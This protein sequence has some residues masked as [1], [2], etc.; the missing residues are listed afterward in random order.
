MNKFDLN[1]LTNN[2]KQQSSNVKQQRQIFSSRRFNQQFFQI[3]KNSRERSTI[4]S[5]FTKKKFFFEINTFNESSNILENDAIF[6][7]ISNFDF[8]DI[9][10]IV[11]NEIQ[12][13]LDRHSK[14]RFKRV[15]FVDFLIDLIVFF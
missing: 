9:L 1:E 10:K 5:F 13:I 11:N 4:L 15:F 7:F 12:R 6:I 14:F 8:F 2:I 3:V